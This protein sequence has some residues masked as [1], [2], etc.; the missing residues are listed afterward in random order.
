MIEKIWGTLPLWEAAGEK[1]RF[2]PKELE[3]TPLRR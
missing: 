3:R 2:V 1:L